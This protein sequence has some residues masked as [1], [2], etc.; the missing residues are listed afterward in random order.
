MAV[1]APRGDGSVA[2]GN[3]RAEHGGADGVLGRRSGGGVGVHH[4]PY[5]LLLV[6]GDVVGELGLLVAGRRHAL[7]TVVDGRA[8]VPGRGVGRV[9]ARLSGESATNVIFFLS[10]VKVKRSLACCDSE[11]KLLVNPK[12]DIFL[13]AL[14]CMSALPASDVIIGC[15]FLVAKVYT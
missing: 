1:A 8:G 10:E 5:F 7:V 3:G 6:L 14:S 13:C 4:L 2:H 11:L 9:Q 12:N 15:S